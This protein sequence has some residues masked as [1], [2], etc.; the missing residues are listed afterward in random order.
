M[1]EPKTG[2]NWSSGTRRTAGESPLTSLERLAV[3][4]CA[5]MVW[6]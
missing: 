5:V 1:S 6:L 3:R 4:L 2:S